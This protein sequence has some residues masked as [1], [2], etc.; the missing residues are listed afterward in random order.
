M[1]LWK[2]DDYVRLYIVITGLHDVSRLLTV[3]VYHALLTVLVDRWRHKTHTF[4]LLVDKA[5]VALQDVA[6]FLG[7]Q[8]EG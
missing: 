5:T 7:L 6:V 1:H 4:H 8:T 3:K 2:L